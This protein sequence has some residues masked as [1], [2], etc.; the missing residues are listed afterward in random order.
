MGSVG[1]TRLVTLAWS[2]NFRDPQ[3][4][5]EDDD[6]MIAKDS[7][8]RNVGGWKGLFVGTC[9]AIV[10]V[11]VC[12]GI[13]M[14]GPPFGRHS[15]RPVDTLWRF[16]YILQ[17]LPLYIDPMMLRRTLGPL[18]K[19][20]FGSFGK[21]VLCEPTHHRRRHPHQRHRRGDWDTINYANEKREENLV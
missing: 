3:S 17:I 13:S 16:Q 14:D 15:S 19:S 11:H 5:E 2:D 6:V 10:I 9:N 1:F 7:T 12:V 8:R 20:R 21:N 4:N 18:I